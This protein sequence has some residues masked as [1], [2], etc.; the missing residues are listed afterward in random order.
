MTSL[1]QF[2]MDLGTNGQIGT[3]L[4]FL[5]PQVEKCL[6]MYSWLQKKVEIAVKKKKRSSRL[7]Q[8][9]QIISF[10]HYQFLLENVHCIIQQSLINQTK[11]HPQMKKI[12]P[13]FYFG[14]L[15]EMILKEEKTQSSA[16]IQEMLSNEQFH[17]SLIVCCIEIF[18]FII[19]VKGGGMERLF[20]QVHIDGFDFWKIL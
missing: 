6:D 20:E 13:Q 9:S 19:Q 10:G 5:S 8:Y 1:S 14:L 4:Q 17:N 16:L 7:Y 2:D 3:G 12:I 18:N 15:E 11:Q